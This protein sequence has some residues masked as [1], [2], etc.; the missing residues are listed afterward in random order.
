MRINELIQVTIC[1]ADKKYSNTISVVI[2]LNSKLVEKYW[3]S[4]LS[5]LCLSFLISEMKI[6]IAFNKLNY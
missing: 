1:L 3:P 6:V 2:I 5:S 4:F